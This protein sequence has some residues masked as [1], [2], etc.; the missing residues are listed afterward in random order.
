M[1]LS[2]VALDELICAAL[3]EQSVIWPSTCCADAEAIF[4]H[5]AQYHG[6]AALL[7][8]RLPQLSTWPPP[9]KEAIRRQAFAQA[10]WE[11]RHQHVIGEA[12]AA[13]RSRGIEPVL[14][15][16][17]ALAYGGVYGNPVWRARGDTDMIVAPHDRDGAAETLVALDFRRDKAVSGEFVSY[18]DS[19]TKDVE[20]GGRHTIDLHWRINNSELLSRL[21]SYAELRVEARSASPLCDAAL[22]AGPVHALMLACLHP[23]THVHNPYMVDDV[24]Y[25]GGDRL[26]WHYDVHL[27]A[28][29]F[30]AADWERFVDR[31]VA[32]G[33]SAICLSALE[34]A[35]ERYGTHVPQFVREG[36]AS[37]GGAVAIYLNAGRLRQAWIDF[38]AIPGLRNRAR[39]AAELV[40]PPA[41]YIRA[42]YGASPDRKLPWLYARRAARGMIKRLRRVPH[43]S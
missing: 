29:S 13:L 21:F 35:A 5:R 31:V 39:F 24:A 11:L 9:I 43:A 10:F 32:K 7:Y 15:K 2:L 12:L 16:G 4:I 26:I 14:F 3:R 41:D 25:Y 6:V 17:T 20:G 19:Y 28:Q 37:T 36:L 40:F 1:V 33:M 8:E 42:K 23:A 18:Q 22:V 27:L 34:R 30:T 38:S